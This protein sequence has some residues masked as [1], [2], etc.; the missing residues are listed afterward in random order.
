M[1]HRTGVP[2]R[3]PG[4]SDGPS[5][6]RS[7]APARRLAPVLVA[8]HRG[9]PL[10]AILVVGAGVLL[11]VA[12]PAGRDQNAL[13]AMSAGPAVGQPS[14]SAS[15]VA[16][17]ALDFLTGAAGID[18][19]DLIGKG[20]V[21][22][23]LLYLTLRVLRRMQAGP[24]AGSR[25]LQVIETRPLGPK[26]SLHLVAIGERRLVVGLSPGGIVALAELD[27]AELAELAGAGEP[28]PF[29][30]MDGQRPV[31]IAPAPADLRSRSRARGSR[32]GRAFPAGPIPHS[33]RR[34]HGL[35][36]RGDDR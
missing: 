29:A 11:L 31:A 34:P 32:C 25:R 7:R 5:G 6:P 26:A 10:A 36:R 13:A 17:S 4:R 24:A 9:F 19:I 21:V 14:S 23:A 35:V 27:A 20:V 3:P 2:T 12:G 15:P 33:T 8:P 18:P 1:A 28:A 30:A 16:A 22:A